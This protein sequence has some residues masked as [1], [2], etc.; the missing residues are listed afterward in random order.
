MKHLVLTA[1]LALAAASLAPAQSVGVGTATPDASAALEVSSSG[2]GVLVPRVALS[3]LT[4]ASTIG[5]PAPSLLVY[6][7]NAALSGG[8]GYY[9]NAGTGAAPQWQRLVT[10]ASLDATNTT[11]TSLGTTSW[12]TTG[13]TLTA[14]GQLGTTSNHHVDL[15]T[16][17]VVRGR[18]SSLGEFFWG[19]TSTA[20]A[21]DLFNA[22]S[23]A[24]F[25]FALNGYSSF[26]G[27]G[28]YGA[29]Q[30]SNTTQFAA[31]QGENNSTTGG[32]NTAGV[33]GTNSSPNAG[34][35]FRLLASTGPRAGVIGSF[36]QSGTYSFGVVGSS[37]GV[38]TR[39]GGLFGDDGG[40]A[41]GSVGYFAQNNLLDYSF[42]GF[43]TAQTVGTTGGRA[44]G[45]PASVNTHIGLGLEGGV[46]GGWVRGQ[47]YGLH[48]RG[49][50]YS[51]YVD[52]PALTNQPLTQ[53]AERPD[54]S[55]AATY[56]PSAL[57]ADVSARGRAELRDG[58]AF[59]AFPADFAALLGN[60][61]EATI[62]VTPTGDTRGVFVERVTETGFYV[63]EN[64]QGHSQAPLHWT[65]TGLRRDA[66]E[67]PLAPELLTRDFDPRM[68][69]LMHSDADPNA[70]T[71]YLWWDGQQLRYDQPPARAA[72]PAPAPA[73]RPQP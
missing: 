43:G 25:P 29:I 31:V 51:L 55:R 11:V 45:S 12:R 32:P 4:D 1:G 23:N 65:A 5:S 61:Q 10:Q 36:S 14:T 28:V 37:P 70:P 20:L 3:S 69:R 60:P 68:R 13:N 41:M 16:N 64:Q 72:A 22:V 40:V 66:R 30:G 8:A 34:T 56:A 48:A 59:V 21:G 19:A 42:Y 71:Q 26:N 53:L 47:V 46:M 7:T 50:R 27:S 9:F 18:L 63:R 17:N 54:G 38:T 33:R 2:K 67:A 49:E 24:T 73:T 15:V 57:T 35:G 52:G 58:T 62:T 39:T 44:A 6:N